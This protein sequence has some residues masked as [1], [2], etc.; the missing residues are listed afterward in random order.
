M[1]PLNK[2]LLFVAIFFVSISANSQQIV[3]YDAT[4]LAMS[5]TATFR[6]DNG[7]NLVNL[8]EKGDLNGIIVFSG[9]KPQTISGKYP[10]RISEMKVENG[11]SLTLKSNVNV[12]NALTLNEGVI[13]LEDNNLRMKESVAIKGNFSKNAMIVPT[14]KGKLEI[15]LN[16]DGK[17]LFPVGDLDGT[18]EYTPASLT[19]KNCDYFDK[20][21]GAVIA[22]R[23]QNEK[24]DKNTSTKNYLNRYWEFSQF[25]ISNLTADV[26]LNFTDADVS[27]TISDEFV[28]SVWL[29]SHWVKLNKVKANKITGT[30]DKLGIFTAGEQKALKINNVDIDDNIVKLLISG[31]NII[32][33][34]T[35][36]F[37]INK[38]E[39]FNKLGQSIK[40]V[41]PANAIYYECNLNKKNDIYLFRISSI[42]QTITKKIF[43]R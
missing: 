13:I 3:I 39:I 40:T 34:S 4:K 27:G 38:I 7:T 14:G 17:Y 42:N 12:L 41:K 25:G 2:I 43:V 37:P 26:E 20:K 33:K 6:L 21:D 10:I 18:I 15:E 22:V 9:P 1:K 31:D 5:P 23:L 32:V 8:S 35:N 11:A 16:K 28:G 36:E 24:F 19:L 30:A 29:G